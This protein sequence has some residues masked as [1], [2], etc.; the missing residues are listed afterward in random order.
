MLDHAA[1][2]SHEEL[3]RLLKCE[4]RDVK[5]ARERLLLRADHL[6]E[7]RQGAAS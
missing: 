1:I 6:R 2:R 5:N 4:P 3:A 7:Q